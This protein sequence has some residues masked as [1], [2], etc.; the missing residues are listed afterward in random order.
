VFFSSLGGARLTA[1]SAGWDSPDLDAIFNQTVAR[2]IYDPTAAPGSNPSFGSNPKPR[3]DGSLS[4]G[5]IVGIMVGILA[6]VV[7][8]L[9]VVFLYWRRKNRSAIDKATIKAPTT[10]QVEEWHKLELDGRQ[11]H[12]LGF[13]SRIHEMQGDRPS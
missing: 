13:E 3:H 5:A 10:L 6:A 7:S 8:T 12:E 1:P 9:V 2:D 11:R 4:N